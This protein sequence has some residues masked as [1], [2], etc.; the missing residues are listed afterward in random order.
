[1]FRAVARNLRQLFTAIA[2][3]ALLLLATEI[4]LQTRTDLITARTVCPQA[5]DELQS[6]LVPSSTA[7]HELLRLRRPSESTGRANFS[8]NSL[9]LRGQEPAIPKPAGLYRVLILGD[10]TVLGPGL[11]EK[12]TLAS[13]LQ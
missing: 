5:S 1:M 3:L 7:H 4:W 9:G 8:T 2:L 10:E 6:V 11:P 12:H 13:R